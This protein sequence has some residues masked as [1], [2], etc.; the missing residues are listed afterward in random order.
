MPVSK[1][2]RIIGKHAA[3][4]QQYA[5]L[6]WHLGTVGVGEVGVWKGAGGL[7]RTWTRRS[8]AETARLVQ[9][10]L[11][12]KPLRLTRRAKTAI[13]GI[14]KSAIPLIEKEPYLFP[15]VLPGGT[16]GRRGL[17]YRMRGE[18]DDGCMRSIALAVS[19]RKRITA[20]IGTTK[21]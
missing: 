3:R 20:Y 8:L 10:A 7:P 5:S 21:K 17:R 19:G 11:E 1:L 16:L 13:P 12:K 18:I 6:S 15:I 9:K 14:L 2:N 4:L